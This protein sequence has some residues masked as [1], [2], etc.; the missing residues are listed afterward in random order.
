MT[1]NLDTPVQYLKGVGP[2]LARLFSKLGVNTVRD[3]IFYFPRNWEDR[4]NVLPISK[5]I[6]GTDCLVKGVIK[7]VRAEKTGRGFNLVKA[8]ISDESGSVCATWFNQPF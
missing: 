3:L 6:T 4:R 2:N 5:L 7:S 1:H 8:L